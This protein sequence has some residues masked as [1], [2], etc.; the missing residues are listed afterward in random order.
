MIYTVVL[1]VYTRNRVFGLFSIVFLGIGLYV[2]MNILTAI[3]YSEFRGYL[4][5]SFL[6]FD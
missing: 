1:D 4:M 2:F 5:A 6:L 3:V